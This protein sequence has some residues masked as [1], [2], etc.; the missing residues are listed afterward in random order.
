MSVLQKLHDS[1][2]NASV[3]SFYD[4]CWTVKLGDEMNGYTAETTVETMVEAE[5]WLD[6]TARAM[7]P[8]SAYAKQRA[9]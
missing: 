9:D 2:I 1:E 3:S 4:R 8:H 6:K 5:Q 7:Y